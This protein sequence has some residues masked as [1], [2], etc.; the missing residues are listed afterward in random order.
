[1]EHLNAIRAALRGAAPVVAIPIE[2]HAPICIKAKLFKNALKGVFVQSVTVLEDR[3]LK[4]TGRVG[5][6]RTSCTFVPMA[7]YEA[8]KAIRD[9]SSKERD[10]RVKVACQ[11]I[12]SAKEQ[13]AMKLKAAEKAGIAELAEAQKIEKE[14]LEEARGRMF[15]V[16]TPMDDD[17]RAE[18]L[19]GWSEYRSTRHLRKRGSVIQWRIKTLK[20][21]YAKLTVTKGKRKDRKT[22]V[23]N[24]ANVLKVLSLTRQIEELEAQFKVLYPPIWRKWES[25]E[26]GGY[27]LYPRIEK[28]PDSQAY[29]IPWG[30]RD[31]CCIGEEKVDEDGKTY[32]TG[33]RRLAA[34]LKDARADIRALTPPADEQEELSIAA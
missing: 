15:P 18:V 20:E 5:M 10:K 12:L 32:L 33:L 7:R 4:V 17:I 1:V 22:Y 26:N 13:R 28:R 11:G 14:I 29:R 2:G 23:R 30:W 16:L 21:E 19:K 8:L 3:R 31:D 25:M 9:W 27:Y 34:R 6:V 24:S